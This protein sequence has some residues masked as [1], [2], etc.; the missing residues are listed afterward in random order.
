VSSSA[1]TPGEPNL[2]DFYDCS[3]VEQDQ[4]YQGE[5]I[6][7]V[8]ILIMPKTMGGW[9]L[10]RTRSGR[11]IDEALQHGSISGP[12]NVLNSNQSKEQW[13][14]DDRG[15]FAMALLDKRPSLVLSQTCDVQTKNFIQVAPIYPATSSEEALERLKTGRIYSAFWLKAHPPEIPQDSYADLERLQ[16]IHKSYIKRIKQEQHF[17][18]KA[19]RIRL[20]QRAITNYFGRPNSYDARNDKAPSCGAYLC[21]WCFYMDGVVTQAQLDQGSP[22]T[23][24]P[25]CGHDQWVMKGR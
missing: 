23:L 17:R 8:P 18:L 10:L 3:P 2:E 6:V 19:D 15:D 25:T 9:T 12:V 20:L 1:N 13:Y 16:A 7:D 14:S 11:R 4:L 5:I 24:C 21:V 22:F